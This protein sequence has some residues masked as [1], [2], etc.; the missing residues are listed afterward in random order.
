MKNESN[1]FTL[2]ELMIVLAII[3]ILST[4]ALPSYQDR[5]IRAQVQEAFY[6]SEFAEKSIEEYYKAKRKLPPLVM[7]SLKDLGDRGFKDAAG[8]LERLFRKGRYE[9]IIGEIH[10]LMEKF[11]LINAPENYA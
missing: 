3:G 11:V 9:Q 5:V 6:L 4:I 10:N 2:I 8:M 1:G 7:D